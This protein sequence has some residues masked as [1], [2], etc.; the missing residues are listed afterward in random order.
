MWFLA[1][2]AKVKS[3]CLNGYS[4]KPAGNGCFP[5]ERKEQKP[6]HKKTHQLGAGEFFVLVL[7]AKLV[8]RAFVVAFAVVFFKPYLTHPD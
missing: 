1:R 4:C 2:F 5:T 3:L 6:A 8:V 7:A